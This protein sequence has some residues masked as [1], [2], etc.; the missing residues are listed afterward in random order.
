LLGFDSA[1]LIKRHNIS[2]WFFL[3]VQ[4]LIYMKLH[5]LILQIYILEYKTDGGFFITLH[6]S[7]RKTVGG[8]QGAYPLGKRSEYSV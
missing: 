6:I 8:I 2:L 7:I 3:F 4:Q 5:V 1:F